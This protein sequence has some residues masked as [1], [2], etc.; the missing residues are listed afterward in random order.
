M[1]VQ[2]CRSKTR[3]R[4][5][6]VLS[7]ASTNEPLAVA[8]EWGIWNEA[9]VRRA[10][11]IQLAFTGIETTST[12]RRHR[13][14]QDAARFH[15]PTARPA[16]A[17]PAVNWHHSG[18]GRALL[19]LN[20]LASSGLVWP[21]AW[22]R[23]LEQHYHVIRVD[24]RGTGWSRSAPNPFT[25]GD[26]ADD[27]RDVL[28]ACGIARATVLGLSLGGMIAQ[29]FAIR[30]PAMVEKLVL[31]GTRPP[32]PAQVPSS[33]DSLLSLL[34]TPPRSGDLEGFFLSIWGDLAAPGFA[35]DH[36]DVM[37]ELADQIT[38]RIPPRSGLLNQGR[39]TW[40]WHGV[41]RLRAITA[42]TTV[43][44]GDRDPL[45]PVGNA[46]RLARLIPNATYVELPGVGH[47]VPQE[48]GHALLQVLES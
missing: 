12:R 7:T 5:G 48:A 46:T 9:V 19:L 21:D 4:L 38:R 27:A 20:G 25:I 39:A 44:H 33:G 26:L 16:K 47:L 31:V 11:D 32:T 23:R 2:S 1:T 6:Q 28:E 8:T 45:I 30:H 3:S 36:P 15:D 37:A 34:Q 18:R 40:S 41:A 17:R 29:E 35:A 24:N 14:L 13:E 22:L 43:V 42:P 10:I